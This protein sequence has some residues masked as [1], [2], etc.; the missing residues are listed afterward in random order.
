MPI[1]RQQSRQLERL[2]VTRGLSLVR[3]CICIVALMAFGDG[4]LGAAELPPS[5]YQVKAA[6]LINFPKYVDWPASAFAQ[7]NS[8]LVIGVLGESKIT[9]EIQ[10]LL[11]TT[12][13]INDRMII[14]TNFASGVEPGGC[15]ILYIPASEQR[16]STDV[17]A[18]LNGST[19]LTVGESADF[20]DGGGIINMALRDKKIAL[21]VNLIAADAARLKISAKLLSVASVVKGKTK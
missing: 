9:A 19:V 5:E 12:R 15:H 11:V 18:K 10:K 1:L 4:M 2:L 17:L 7:T 13:T 14:F 21:E 8:A 3:K 20:L 16:R 6:F